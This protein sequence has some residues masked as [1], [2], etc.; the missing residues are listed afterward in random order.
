[1][2]ED[3]VTGISQRKLKHLLLPVGIHAIL[4]GIAFELDE[5]DGLAIFNKTS[6]AFDS[7]FP[8]CHNTTPQLSVEYSGITLS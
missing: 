2:E 4:I 7:P 3:V 6:H 5:N 1:V 8:V